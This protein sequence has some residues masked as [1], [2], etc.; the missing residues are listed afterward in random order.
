[1]NPETDLIVTKDELIVRG[2][3]AVADVRV[4]TC[5]T[6]CLPLI[7]RKKSMKSYKWPPLARLRS[8]L[9]GHAEAP[10]PSGETNGNAGT[11]ENDEAY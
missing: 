1:M 7:C 11:G 4:S 10:S 6:A 2:C 5:A 9:C 3:K 8:S